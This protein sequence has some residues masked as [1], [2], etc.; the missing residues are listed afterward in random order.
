[1]SRAKQNSDPTR[2][3]DPSLTTVDLGEAACQSK[4]TRLKLWEVDISTPWSTLR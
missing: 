2:E 4:T 3:S 1:M